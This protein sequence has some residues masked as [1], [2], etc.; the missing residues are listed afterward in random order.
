MSD[1]S[2]PAYPTIMAGTQYHQAGM[3]LRDYFAG[4][5]MVGTCIAHVMIVMTTNEVP[6]LLDERAASR[7]NYAFADAMLAERKKAN[8]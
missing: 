8:E 7:A 3:S 2:N 6:P 5:A 1:Y 4:Q